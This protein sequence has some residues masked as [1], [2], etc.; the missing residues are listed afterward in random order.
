MSHKLFLRWSRL[1]LLD[2]NA[3]SAIFKMLNKMEGIRTGV[4]K[5]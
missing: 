4:N 3:K 5:R 1:E 2:K